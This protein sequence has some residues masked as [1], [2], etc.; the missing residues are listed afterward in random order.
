MTVEKFEN[1]MDNLSKLPKVQQHMNKLH[2]QLAK[3]IYGRRLEKGLTQ[4]NVVELIRKKGGKV[5]QAQLSRIETA[6][7][8]I[9]IATYEEVLEVLDFDNIDITFRKTPSKRTIGRRNT[10]RHKKIVQAE[11]QLIRM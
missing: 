2:V 1:I 8:K 4:T 5:T 6:N 3:Q 7:E 9:N 10:S 11:E